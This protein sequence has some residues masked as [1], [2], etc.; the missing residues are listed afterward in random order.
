M[1]DCLSDSRVSRLVSPSESL[2]MLVFEVLLS[3]WVPVS[4]PRTIQAHSACL[5]SRVF[6]GSESQNRDYIHRLHLANVQPLCAVILI[7]IFAEVLGLYGLIVALILN[8]RSGN[9][10]P[11]SPIETDPISCCTDVGR[12][13]LNRSP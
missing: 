9:H 7:L 5:Q 3:R 10:P 11:V 8:T 1:L 13:V 4:P 12:T 6:V 2:E